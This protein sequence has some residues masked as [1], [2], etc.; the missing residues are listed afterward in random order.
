MQFDDT[1][2]IISPRLA[3][4][5]QFYICRLLDSNSSVDYSQTVVTEDAMRVQRATAAQMYYK[6]YCNISTTADTV[7]TKSTKLNETR[8]CDTVQ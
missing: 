4:V 8:H 2:Y 3:R 1:V 6:A 7:S 5:S